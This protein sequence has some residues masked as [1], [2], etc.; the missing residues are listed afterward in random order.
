MIS[1]KSYEKNIVLENSERHFYYSNSIV[2][3]HYHLHFLGCLQRL[4]AQQKNFAPVKNQTFRWTKKCTASL[5]KNRQFVHKAMSI[6]SNIISAITGIHCSPQV[7]QSVVAL[8]LWLKSKCFWYNVIIQRSCWATLILATK[9]LY[10]YTPWKTLFK[11]DEVENA[12]FY[13]L[14]LTRI[15][16]KACLY[17]KGYTACKQTY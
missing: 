16:S 4:Q 11:T 10:T 15:E 9:L 12:I 14:A 17:S 5:N 2:C 1:F 6:V 3:F 7:T 13:G 8:R